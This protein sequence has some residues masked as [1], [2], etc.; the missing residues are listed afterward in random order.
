MARQLLGQLFCWL[1]GLL[2][3]TH[4]I[5]PNII[6]MDQKDQ[7]IV[8]TFRQTF[9]QQL[10]QHLVFSDMRQFHDLVDR[11]S[12]QEKL[13]KLSSKEA[14]FGDAYNIPRDVHNSLPW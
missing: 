12:D 4:Y 3:S 9:G 13:H 8:D 1:A 7:I 6:N 10:I 14:V 11:G 5:D 2:D